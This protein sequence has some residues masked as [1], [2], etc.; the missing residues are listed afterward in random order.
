MKKLP[1]RELKHF[2]STPEL[3][4]RTI[5]LVALSSANNLIAEVFEQDESNYL[6]ILD[7]LTGEVY[8]SFA[9]KSF[10][11]KILTFSQN[12]DLL[13]LLERKSIKIFRVWRTS[14]KSFSF[15]W[16]EEF[17][18]WDIEAAAWL[19][20]KQ[21]LLAGKN[22]NKEMFIALLDQATGALKILL[23]K[24]IEE[25]VDDVACSP[26]GLVAFA[27]GYGNQIRLYQLNPKRNSLIQKD[28]IIVLKTGN[29]MKISLSTDGQFIMSI[30]TRGSFYE[31]PKLKLFNQQGELLDSLPVSDYTEVAYNHPSF[32]IKESSKYSAREYKFYQVQNR[33]FRLWCNVW[34][35]P[36][37]DLV[38]RDGKTLVAIT[39]E[40]NTIVYELEDPDILL[41]NFDDNKPRLEGITN[42]GKRRFEPAT[43]WLVQLLQGEDPEV[44]IAACKAL[45]K[46]KS[47]EALS[48]II[49]AIGSEEDK[50]LQK[51][52]KSVLWSFLLNDQTTA[53]IKTF[54]AKSVYSRRGAAKVLNDR[55]NLEVKTALFEAVSDSDS[56]TRLLATQALHKKADL[57][58]CVYLMA[59]LYD[60]D[61]K[62]R[63]AV[64]KAI[65]RILSVNNLFPKVLEKE[66]S[67]PFDLVVYA[68]KVIKTGR[69]CNFEKMD[70]TTI[71]KFLTGL[72][73]A[74]I[75]SGSPLPLILNKIDRLTSVG[76]RA[77]T[78]APVGM[79][80]VLSLACAEAMLQD[81]QWNAAIEIYR[82][83]L[84][85]TRLLEAPNMEW[86]IHYAIGKCYE[87]LKKDQKALE[88][89]RLAIGVID[90]WWYAVL[91]EDKLQH[92]FEDKALLYDRAALCSLRLGYY[93]L[94]FEFGEKAKTRF[95]GDLIARRQKDPKLQL[96]RSLRYFWENVGDTRSY[97][98]GLASA[99]LHKASKPEVILSGWDTIQAG[100]EVARPARLLALED[101]I[102]TN[103]NYQWRLDM[104]NGIWEVAA[105]V[106]ASDD[107][108]VRSNLEEIYQ[109]LL[110]FYWWR[111]NAGTNLTGG[112][113]EGLLDQ[114]TE[115]AEII[116][117]DNP[118]APFWV[119]REFISSLGEVLRSPLV[120]G[121]PEFL[122]AIMEALNSI[123]Q[124]EP[125]YAAYPE[126]FE[127]ETTG[128][129]LEIRQGGSENPFSL[130]HRS[131]TIETTMQQHSETDWRYV[132]KLARG[133][134]C[135]Y[136]ELAAM[137][138]GEANTAF[139]QFFVSEY[140]TVT[141]LVFGQDCVPNSPDL[142]PDI[143]GEHGIKVFTNKK[144]T[145]SKL[146]EQMVAA[147][148]SWFKLYADRHISDGF[149]GWKEALDRKQQW[150]YSELIEPIE[151]ELTGHNIKH[152][153]IVPH[154]ALHLIP[155]AALYKTLENGDRQ[156]LIEK[157]T[158]RYAP[159]ATL[160]Q[161]CRE[162]SSKLKREFGLTAIS[163]PT[164]DLEY[165]EEEVNIIKSYFPAA[166]VKVLNG[167]TATRKNFLKTKPYSVFHYAGHG[168]YNWNDPLLSNMRLAGNHSLV[169]GEFFDNNLTFPGMSLAVL[170]ACETDITDPEDLADE[171][172]GLTSGF[173]FA[174]SQYVLGTLWAVDDC[175]TFLLM[176]YF[177]QKCFR[178]GLQPPV[179][180]QEAQNWLRKLTIEESASEIKKLE[181]YLANDRHLQ[182][183]LEE[184]KSSQNA[185]KYPFS[186]PYYWAAFTLLGF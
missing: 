91:D 98:V 137:F 178:E 153:Q 14:E 12:G 182:P 45:E 106:L 97:R 47:P 180:L 147:P 83:S 63:H 61:K 36:V 140:G 51:V 96:E 156:Y 134:I 159:S 107:G 18:D 41:L 152:L 124:N 30:M 20:N 3:K 84:N 13:F 67:K 46:I 184:N 146:K 185:A 2:G 129:I 95:L 49:R 79:S 157:F 31:G 23:E 170:S 19:D 164:C 29:S 16:I 60:E 10:Y 52:F 69:V 169:L 138:I 58:A 145:L 163:N 37:N 35:D 117:R 114:Y 113:I 172:L 50:N 24:K 82:N 155:F 78:L 43:K 64:H 99:R 57:R 87:E 21:I 161:I 162:R 75:K 38:T 148:D 127:M 77:T 9:F 135:T 123:L 54:E 118:S 144:L 8:S 72:G 121:G 109:T 160:M 154:R 66:F 173:L 85:N 88:A 27:T 125:I 132:F 5:K 15:H 126:P 110:P 174:G 39:N 181:N 103:T 115:T 68:E 76:R 143:K 48:H 33:K 111:R 136:R 179:A 11:P 122:D 183:I 59:Q 165:A 167:K 105:W 119:F 175:S 101:T 102:K 40:H 142:L 116:R 141:Y 80:L 92:F 93:E 42:L 104:V 34:N 25:Y 139:L 1:L 89:Y 17:G 73:T 171:Y 6:R 32:Y 74:C 131:T 158:V 176:R 130:S 94:A 120:D 71:G 28:S 22:Y 4:D 151:S 150:L 62:I 53:L 86:R 186:H 70:N 81:Q 56:P 65:V 166:K 44:K 128:P 90:R 100:A 149:N 55:P 108:E 133:E 7:Y 112:Q 177:Y 26:S 168:N